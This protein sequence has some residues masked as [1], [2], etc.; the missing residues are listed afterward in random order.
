MAEL[1][2]PRMRGIVTD[3][4]AVFM[5]LGYTIACY[6]GLAF[7]FVEGNNQWRGAL[8]IQTVLPVIIL[9]GIYWMPE[10]PRYLL[11]KDRIEEARD[12][13]HR[14]HSHPSDPEDLF[15]KWE[16]YQIR[17]QIELDRTFATSYREIFKKPSM[18]K[19]ALTTI[20]LEFCLMSSGVLTILSKSQ[21]PRPRTI[22]A[23][24]AF[25]LRLHHLESPWLQHGSDPQLPVRFP[26]HRA[27]VQRRG[28]DICG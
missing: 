13:I 18:R 22:L 3:I 2:P 20:F 7:Y 27:R 21:R 15:A 9:C 28:Y 11:S 25:R 24:Q 17:K 23:N 5:M 12:I 14:M 4:H 8:S 26:A 16:F 6:C 1:S 19:R 10:S